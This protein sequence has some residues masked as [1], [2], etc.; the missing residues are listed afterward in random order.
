VRHGRDCPL[1]IAIRYIGFTKVYP[2]RRN[3]AA[4]CPR[5]SEASRGDAMS[6]L[7][8][9]AEAEVAAP[10]HDTPAGGTARPRLVIVDPNRLRR[11]CL[12]MAVLGL[13]WPVAAVPS[14][15]ELWRRVARGEA[16]D[17]VLIGGGA[18]AAEEVARLAAAVPR[19]PIV[20]AVDGED[21]RHAERLL[22]AGARDVLPANTGLRRLIATL[23][24][25]CGAPSPPPGRGPAAKFS[26]RVLTRR[27]REVLTLISEG[28]SNRLIAAALSL[29]E[30]T[31][32]AHVKQIIRR[33]KVAN[34]TQAALIATGASRGPAIPLAGPPQQG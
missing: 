28:K 34:R 7:E 12:R 20:V 30:E 27:Q 32:K 22:S 18:I 16:Y 21:D 31:V 25:I 2:W 24:R 4:F 8:L 9:V 29:S 19:L 23:A 6:S 17:A 10:P 5:Y 14:L 11:D 1:T 33:L 3:P 15:H 13:G 26:A